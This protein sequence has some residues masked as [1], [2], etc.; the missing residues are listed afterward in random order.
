MAEKENSKTNRFGCP[1][2]TNCPVCGKAGEVLS[3]ICVEILVA[4]HT[5]PLCRVRLDIA[6]PRDDSPE[7]EAAFLAA[8]AEE[9]DE[10]EN[11]GVVSKTIN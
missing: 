2:G 6:G 3:K 8:M 4:M 9:T 1:D 7:A 10:I 5:L 11:Q